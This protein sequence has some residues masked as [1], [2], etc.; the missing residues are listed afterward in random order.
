MHP[1]LLFSTLLV[2]I[3]ISALA[4]DVD[5]AAAPQAPV[6]PCTLETGPARD[7][8]FWIGEWEVVN[9]QND[10]VQGRNVI[11]RREGGCLLLE[12]WTGTA[13]GTGL[14]MNFY[15]P[16]REHWRQVW[17][18]AMIRVE[19]TGNLD[20]EGRMAMEGHIHYHAADQG[21]PFRGRW[22]P[23]EDGTVLQE[24]WENRDGENWTPWFVGLYRPSD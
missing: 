16:D 9:P 8:D 23:N 7:F 3:S 13:G 4:Q 15:E 20:D 5:T 22:T 21:F 19:L 1:T 18:S 17:Q 2:S 11:T 14:S 24:F 10:Q 12:D 6:S